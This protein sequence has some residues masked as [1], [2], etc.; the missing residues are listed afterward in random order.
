MLALKTLCTSLRPTT[1]RPVI[2]TSIIIPR[3]VTI[4]INPDSQHEKPIDA[5]PPTT[6]YVNRVAAVNV[7][8]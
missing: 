5:T 3:L 8:K 1:T 4:I 6:R 7:V 2:R